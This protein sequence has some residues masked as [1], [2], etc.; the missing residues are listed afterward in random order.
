MEE[1]FEMKLHNF[2]FIKSFIFKLIIIL[3]AI[4]GIA[5][6]SIYITLVSN[7]FANKFQMHQ[8]EKRKSD[9]EERSVFFCNAETLTTDEQLVSSSISCSSSQTNIVAAAATA[10]AVASQNTSLTDD[11][12][13]SIIS[14]KNEIKK[15]KRDSCCGRCCAYLRSCCE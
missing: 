14:N 3:F 13:S 9:C 1:I 11:S 10:L 15:R 4:I 12:N 6:L 7:F 5:Q 8:E 2:S